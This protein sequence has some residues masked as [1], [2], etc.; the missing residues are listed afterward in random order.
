MDTQTPPRPSKNAVFIKRFSYAGQ[1]LLA[2]WKR[3]SS[4]RFQICCTLA[5][6]VFCLIIQPSAIWCAIFAT[7]A[8]LVLVLELVNSALEALLD[9]LHPEA[10]PEIGFV[11][12]CLSG[13]VLVASVISVVVF[14]FFVTANRL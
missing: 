8:A 3:E 7:N 4:F 13:A 11:K 12:D 2:A 14:L 6:I 5:L 1:G 9:R 10:H